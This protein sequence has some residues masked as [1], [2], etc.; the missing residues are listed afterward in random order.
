MK[1]FDLFEVSE[2]KVEDPGLKRYINVSPMLLPKNRGRERARF[3][4]AD[5]NIVE[6]LINALQVPGHRGKKHKVMTFHA[7][8]KWGR[9]ATAVIE[10]F[11]IIEKKTGKNPVQVL[12]TAVENAAPRDEITSIE[13]GGARYPQ[14]VD[15][16]PSRRV[17][18]ALKN[19]VHAAQDKSFG[20]KASLEAALADELIAAYSA[21]NESSSVTKKIETEKMADSAR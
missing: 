10:A 17:A 6:R 21:S 15:V 1:L 18:I 4:K 8:G 16:A 5:I 2:V 14:A 12:V 11:K 19:I 3:A 7:S 9:N 13:Y 20:K